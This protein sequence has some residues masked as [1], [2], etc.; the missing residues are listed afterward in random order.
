METKKIYSDIL[1]KLYYDPEIGLG[2]IA[3]LYSAAK[4][5][6]SAITMKMVKEFI[7]NQ[8]VSQIFKERR[9][10]NNFPL[11]ADVPLSR[12]QVDLL[13]IDSYNPRQNGGNK[14][15]FLAIDVF[16]RVAFAVPQKNKTDKECLRSFKEIAEDI[17]AQGFKITR[18]DSDNEAGF[19][20]KIFSDYCKENGIAQHLNQIGDHKA[21]GVIDRFCRTLRNL[22]SRYEEVYKTQ[23]FIPVLQKLIDNYNSS[24][25]RTLGQSPLE[26][27]AFG[28][29]TD[30]M[31][32]QTE[33]AKGELYN[34]EAFAVGDRVRVLKKK[35]L[36]NKGGNTFSKTVYTISEIE[37]GRYY[38]DGLESGY[39]KSELLKVNNDVEDYEPEDRE[40]N[41]HDIDE[42]KEAQ[43]VEKRISR[44][45]NKEG[46]DREKDVIVDVNEKVLRRY[47]KERDFGPMLLQ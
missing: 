20:S 38:V 8:K 32:K 4:R 16:S 34:K 37:G 5:V 17:K 28:G 6:N 10:K 43:K 39:R 30:Y 11:I 44:R 24:A 22:I 19:K 27:L 29:A 46:I 1:K 35:I 41:D 18:L 40:E 26:A 42:K 47:R 36:F 9:V 7:S 3:K 14:F 13:D 2:G 45:I 31:I 21:L 15:L 23:R 12:I 33:R 25:H